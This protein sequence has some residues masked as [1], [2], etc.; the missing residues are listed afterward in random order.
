[1]SI[2]FTVG[3]TLLI[4]T[5]FYRVDLNENLY[6]IGNLMLGGALGFYIG[7][8][9]EMLLSLK[10]TSAAFTLAI[11]IPI[12]Y[13]F[14]IVWIYEKAEL[15]IEDEIIS[16]LIPDIKKYLESENEINFKDWEWFTPD[17]NGKIVEVRYSLI[18]KAFDRGEIK[19]VE[20]KEERLVKTS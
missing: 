14:I 5:N 4:N 18:K 20:L 8:Y 11:L 1:M 13:A 15:K 12:I 19:N 6:I 2:I 16:N 3:L 7:M 9:I 17:P 10:S